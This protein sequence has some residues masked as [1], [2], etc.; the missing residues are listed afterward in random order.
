VTGENQAAAPVD[1]VIKLAFCAL[2]FGEITRTACQH[3][4]GR[5]ETDT[6]HTVMLAWLAPAL[7]DLLYPELDPELVAA[8][9][10]VHDAVEVYAGDTPT[11]RITPAGR[12]AK[13]AREAA[14]VH[15]WRQDFGG[16]LPWL[17]AMIARYEAQLEPEARFTRAVDKILPGLVHASN[18]ARDLHE[19]GMTAAEQE[20]RRQHHRAE[21]EQ[22]AAD[23]PAILD[24]RGEMSAML[25]VLLRE[26]EAAGPG[27]D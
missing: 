11:L 19:Y 16:T 14:A 25:T 2:E 4:D 26:R 8:F 3:P 27:K 15:R 10:V 1:A 21:M 20:E 17:P 13:K 22:Y 6:T 7:A 5:L 9:A 18:G 12:E 23:F 24:L